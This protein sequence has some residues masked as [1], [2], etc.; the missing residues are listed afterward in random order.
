[1]HLIDDID[2]IFSLIGFE[3]GFFDKVSD[4]FDAIIARTI[5]LDTV[6]HG[7]RVE[8]DTVRACMTRIPILEICTVDSLGEDTGTRRLTGSARSMEEIGMIDSVRFQAISEDSCDV[9]LSDDA[10]PVMRT[11]GCIERHVLRK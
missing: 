6:E 2:L 8:S 5:D 4:I 11:I 1:M 3:S 10:V 9:I 7:S